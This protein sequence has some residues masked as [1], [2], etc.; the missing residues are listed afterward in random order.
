[1]H[2]LKKVFSFV[3]GLGLILNLCSCGYAPDNDA[4]VITI[5]SS[6]TSSKAAY[7]N[8]IDS[9]NN[10]IGL[11]NNIYINYETKDS[12]IFKDELI[13]AFESGT[14]PD[15][16]A[17][18]PVDFVEQGRVAAIEDIDGGEKFLES[19]GEIPLR[20]E[21]SY[22]GKV[23]CLPVAV[24]THGLLY[25]KDMFIKAGLVD[26][27]GD[28]DPPETFD[29]LREYAKILT[30]PSKDEYGIVLPLKWSGWYGS[31]IRS[32]MMS[33]CG[34]QE[35]N[36]V[37][38]LYD[39]S[40]AVSIMKTFLGI[41]E[42]RSY[43][44]GADT[45]DNDT[46]RALFASGGVG[47]KFAFSFDVGVLNDQYPADIDWGVAPLPVVDK[48][49]K[50]KQRMACGYTF[51]VNSE[52]LDKIEHR[53]LIEVLKFFTSDDT[54]RK[55]Y[56]NSTTIPFNMSVIEKVDNIE[57][58]KGWKEFCD[59]VKIS[60]IYPE[61]PE[62]NLISS[63]KIDSV[64]V[65]EVWTGKITPEECAQKCADLINKSVKEHYLKLPDKE[66]EKFIIPDWDIKR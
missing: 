2:G 12:L 39:Y 5:W 6:S 10:S 51:S 14:A 49:N 25:N 54:I 57:H 64:F 43:V 17:G 28:P 21:N 9:F 35:F 30:N 36:P 24:T 11:A 33:S 45:L 53:K 20:A 1:M 34:Y 42:D 27:N 7:E 26:E 60:E 4:T 16:F 48:N 52:A 23:Y 56:A 66:F 61:M 13:K 44:P 22:D 32:P 38:G 29:E 19:F 63:E 47:M 3:L 37:T 58:K 55:L 18:F 46:A 31:D 50:Y 41:K 65:E 62:N 59:L 15:M 8:L 40:G